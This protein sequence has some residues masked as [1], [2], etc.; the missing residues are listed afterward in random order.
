M[1]SQKASPVRCRTFE[2]EKQYLERTDKSKFSI[3]KGF[4]ANMNV[5][6]V[7]Y[8]NQELQK[9]MFD[10]LQSYARANVKTG[11]GG[12]SGGFLPAVKQIANVASLPGIVK[13]SIG[14]PDVHAGKNYSVVLR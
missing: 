13:Y 11:G 4:V 7:F 5:E 10:E 2:Q 8:A 3:R 9:L 12:A 1:A 6:G 14:L